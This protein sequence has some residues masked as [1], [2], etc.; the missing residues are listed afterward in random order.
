MEFNIK[1]IKSVVKRDVFEYPVMESFIRFKGK[2]NIKD[3][4]PISFAWVDV[5]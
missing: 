2:E 4:P 1:D 3:M 5:M